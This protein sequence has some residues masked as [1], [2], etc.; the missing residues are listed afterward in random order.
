MWQA[1][2]LSGEEMVLLKQNHSAL[3]YVKPALETA[4]VWYWEGGPDERTLSP[5]HQAV[6]YDWTL[7][8]AAGP[9]DFL[10]WEG[11]SK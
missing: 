4:P 11:H 3:A 2:F 8:K 1:S 7:G 9:L 6:H 5:L 10:S